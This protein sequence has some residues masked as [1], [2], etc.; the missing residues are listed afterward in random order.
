MVTRIE[1]VEL[2]CKIVFNR[3]KMIDENIKQ[4]G[5]VVHKVIDRC[6]GNMSKISLLEEVNSNKDNTFDMS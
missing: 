1:N 2:K 3:N 6:K 4:M 5:T